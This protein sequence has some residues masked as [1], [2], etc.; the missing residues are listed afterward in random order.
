MMKCL[1]QVT[2]V[3]TRTRGSS[4][5]PKPFQLPGVEVTVYYSR[6]V[7]MMPDGSPVEGVGIAPEVELKLPAGAYAEK[8]PTWEKARELLRR[9][10][11]AFER[12]GDR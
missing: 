3:G 2:T 9:K 7:D 10:A 5:N 1:P 4:G 8:D 6:W 12:E 11:E